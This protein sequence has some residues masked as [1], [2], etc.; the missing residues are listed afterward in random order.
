MLGVSFRTNSKLLSK[1]INRFFKEIPDIA[2]QGVKKSAFLLKQII[3]QRTAKGRGL[4]GAFFGYSQSYKE[5]LNKIGAPSVV[6][7]RLTGDMLGSIQTKLIN[8]RKASI[9]FG[10][11][12]EEEKAVRITR[13][14]DRPFFGY[15]DKEGKF[16]TKQFNIFAKKELR[17]KWGRR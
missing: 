15:T 14:Q 2:T 7:L 11:K 13:D 8:K 12:T 4:R 1:R 5:Y 17:K 16:I 10:R 3:L 6:D 9:Y